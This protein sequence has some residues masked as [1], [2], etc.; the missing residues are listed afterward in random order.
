[1]SKA[2]AYGSRIVRDRRSDPRYSTA[3][4]QRTRRAILARDLWRCYWTDCPRTASCVDHIVPVYAGMPD[5]EFFDPLNLRASC[6][7]HNLV[8]PYLRADEEVVE[9]PRHYAYGRGTR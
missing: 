9:R 7:N 8:R 4:W 3:R 6:R 2:R 5:S 1:M